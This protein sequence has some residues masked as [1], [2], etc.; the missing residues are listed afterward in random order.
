MTTTYSG[1]ARSR[2][3]RRVLG[4]VMAAA[5]GIG[6]AGFVATSAQALPPVRLEVTFNPGSASLSTGGEAVRVSVTVKNTDLLQASEGA[7]GQVALTG[8]NEHV[9]M[10]VEAGN[11]DSAAGNSVNCGT[12]DR[13]ASKTFNVVLTPKAGSALPEGQTAS[14][15][16]DVTMSPPNQGSGSA[17]VSIVGSK[18]TATGLSGNVTDVSSK[19][20]IEGV[21]VV[22]KDSKGTS[23]PEAQ[24]DAAGNYR[25]VGEIAAGEVEV[26]FSKD[27]YRE[28]VKKFTAVAGKEA[29]GDA[30]MKKAAKDEPTAEPSEE[31]K[32]EKPKDEGGFGVTMWLLIILGALLVI[33]G[34]VAIVLLFRKGKDDDNDDDDRPLP[35]LP[36]THR[37]SATQTGQLGV[38]DAARHRPGMDAPTMIHNGPLIADDDLAQYGSTPTSGGGFGPSYEGTN[39]TSG[40][41]FGPSYGDQRQ[42]QR[43]DSG[44]GDYDGRDTNRYPASGPPNQPNEYDS[45]DTRGYPPASPDPNRGGWGG[46]YDSRYDQPPPQREPYGDQAQRDPY[47]QT[48]PNRGGRR[49]RDE[50]D[51]NQEQRHRW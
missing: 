8:V 15:T 26:T 7:G 32:A 19:E 3:G 12:I 16:I 48:P 31:P 2:W 37:P 21:K 14:G 35:D 9:D 33:G 38:Y 49:Y 42:T 24:T 43:F 22:A 30:R 20:P 46:G 27:G 41:G 6:G 51:D 13:G 10:T 17:G 50:D 45:R 39:P 40:G 11:C 5:L 1:R 28:D 47:D 23:L 29:K 34:I 25:I 4:T 44:P 18:Q 36:P